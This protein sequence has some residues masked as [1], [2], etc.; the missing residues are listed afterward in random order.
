MPKTKENKGIT[1]IAL[2]ITIIVLLILAGVT[3]SAISG[4]ESVLEKAKQAKNRTDAANLKEQIQLAVINAYANN[5]TGTIDINSLKT[6]LENEGITVTNDYMPAQVEIN[7]EYY[8]VD[9]AGKAAKCKIPE[10]FV[11]SQATGENTIAGGLVIYEGTEAVTDSNVATARTTRNQFVWVPVEDA[12]LTFAQDHT[13]DSKHQYEYKNY[14]DWD[15]EIGKENISSV[16]K[17]GGFYIGRYEAGW[18]DINQELV[19]NSATNVAYSIKNNNAKI[20]VMKKGYAAWDLV[21]Q[22][23][24]KTVSENLYKNSSTVTNVKSQLIDS[25]AWDTTVNWLK[26]SGIVKEEA[27]GKI[28]SVDYGNYVDSTF[29]ITNVLY[30]PHKWNSSTSSWSNASTY[31]VGSFTSVARSSNME[32]ENVYIKPSLSLGATDVTKTNNIYDLAGNLWEWTTEK[33]KHNANGDTYAVLRGGGFD[34]GGSGLPVVYRHGDVRVG[35]YGSFFI[36]FRPVLYL[37]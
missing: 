34:G 13:Y 7:G 1:L 37:Q 20:P 17:Y 35:H 9:N 3:I 23:T 2:I 30:A 5:G 27:N 33:G 14:T 6:N 16:E 22:T 15:D 28:K 31:K 24:A 21:S 12:G 11:A 8:V 26:Q 36:G 18:P 4:N 32:S 19:E 25:L 10:G 29:G